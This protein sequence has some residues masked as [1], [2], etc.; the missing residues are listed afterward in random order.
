[1]M[2]IGV[3]LRNLDNNYEALNNDIIE[4]L[5]KKNCILIGIV[6][7]QNFD[8]IKNLIDECSGVILPGGNYEMTN[9]R[10]IIEYL[11]EINKPTL[12]ICL[13]AEEMAEYFGG[14][15]IKMVNNNH[16]SKRNY[17]HGIH[18]INNTLFKKIINKDYIFV[19]SRHNYKIKD[20]KLVVSS[21]SDDYIIESIESSCKKFFLGVCYHPESL[22]NDINSK[23]LIDYFMNIC[24]E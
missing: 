8:N 20:T 22:K 6:V 19:N 1:M 11:Y 14:K 13:G 10:K 5:N 12:G 2:K 23:N 4:Y 7:N 3:V 9:D 15:L 21:Y 24:Y 18:I 16:N 17:V